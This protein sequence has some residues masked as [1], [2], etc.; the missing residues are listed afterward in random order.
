VGCDLPQDCAENYPLAFRRQS[1]EDMEIAALSKTDIIGRLKQLASGEESQYHAAYAL[2][3]DRVLDLLTVTLA[4]VPGSAVLLVVAPEREIA[5]LEPEYDDDGLLSSELEDVTVHEKRFESSLSQ[6]AW[7]FSGE[8]DSRGRPLDSA[9]AIDHSNGKVLAAS[10]YFPS[11]ATSIL[12]FSGQ[13]YMTAVDIAA[14][15]DR[16]VVFTRSKQGIVNVY[17]AAEAQWGRCLKVAMPKKDLER[18][19]NVELAVMLD[20]LGH[21]H[22][23]KG[24]PQA[25]KQLHERALRIQEAHYGQHHVPIIQSTYTIHQAKWQQTANITSL[26][27]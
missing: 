11:Q 25:A 13:E 18:G 1:F 17:P 12:R 10:A 7:C 4:N 16:G 5:C 3:L 8:V 14:A 15:L 6:C 9:F 2:V 23:Q 20:N 26:K 22:L 19:E 21:G 27:K 24:N